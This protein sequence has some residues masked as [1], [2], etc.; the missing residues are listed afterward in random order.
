MIAQVDAFELLRQIETLIARETAAIVK[1][2]E[3]AERRRGR[4]DAWTELA[5]NIR[6]RRAETPTATDYAAGGA[7]VEAY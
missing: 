3:G 4:I 7:P 1:T 6:G 5:A 2:E